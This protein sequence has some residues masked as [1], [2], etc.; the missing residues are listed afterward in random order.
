MHLGQPG[1]VSDDHNT[2]CSR[3]SQDKLKALCLNY[4]FYTQWRFW[5]IGDQNLYT[6]AQI[7]YHLCGYPILPQHFLRGQ[8]HT[9]PGNMTKAVM[10]WV[11]LQKCSIFEIESAWF[12]HCRIAQSAESTLGL[13]SRALDP[14][15]A[16]PLSGWGLCLYKTTC[17][18]N[19]HGPD[20]A[21]IKLFFHELVLSGHRPQ[22]KHFHAWQIVL[23]YSMSLE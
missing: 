20:M 12:L 21:C 3:V 4:P 5:I 22:G 2:H 1:R 7:K 14:L 15:L 10:V 6:A 17:W 23:S 19:A 18:E 9:I 13:C 8:C 11:L 16:D